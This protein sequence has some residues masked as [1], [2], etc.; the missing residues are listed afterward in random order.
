MA[1]PPFPPCMLNAQ[2]KVSEHRFWSWADLGTQ[3]QF[4]VVL[5][6]LPVLSVTLAKFLNFIF[7]LFIFIS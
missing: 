4:F 1:L 5:V 3:V 7:Y 2:V 6:F